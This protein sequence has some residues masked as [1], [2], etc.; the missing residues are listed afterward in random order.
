MS[1][2]LASCPNG[3]H[4]S[5]CVC[6]CLMLRQDALL[7]DERAQTSSSAYLHTLSHTHYRHTYPAINTHTAQP[8]ERIAVD[9]AWHKAL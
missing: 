5:P 3:V 9:R 8:Q 7:S 4:T 1:M 6:V 2:V